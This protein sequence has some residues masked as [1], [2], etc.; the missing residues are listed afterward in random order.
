MLIKSADSVI[1]NK[2]VLPL[3]N[4]SRDDTIKFKPK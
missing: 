3:Q 1:Y 4:V 2:K